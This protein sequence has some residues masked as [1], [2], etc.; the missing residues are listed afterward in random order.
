[1]PD[2]QR[3]LTTVFLHGLTLYILIS[4]ATNVLNPP[5]GAAAAAPFGGLTYNDVLARWLNKIKVLSFNEA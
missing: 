5:A 4:C 1:M 2:C 3:K